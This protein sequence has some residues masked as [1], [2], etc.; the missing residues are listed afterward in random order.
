MFDFAA[1]FSVGLTYTQF[2][3]A[4]GTDDQKRRWAAVR[5]RVQLTP[6]QRARLNGFKREMKVLVLA[7]AWC[8][9]CVNQCPIFDAFADACPRIQIRYL[10]RDA[11]PD[12]ANAIRVCGA[13]RV[14][15]V[16][17]LSEDDFFCGQ[18]GDRTL[19]RYRE[20]A[21]Q[22]SG[23]ACSTGIVPLGSQGSAPTRE[24]LQDWIDDWLNEFERVQLML[25]TSAR[26][27]EKHGD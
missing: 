4:H 7:G 6:P 17:F 13:P 19:S 21:S 14:P 26:L 23:A 18:Y 5:E 24:P 10:D 27:R 16:V 8:G 2:L 1:S 12:L 9:D 25:R 20:L 3:D 15:T 22:L 11:N